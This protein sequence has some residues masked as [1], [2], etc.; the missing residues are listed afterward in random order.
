[1]P[2]TQ[3]LQ[4]AIN[5][6]AEAIKVRTRESSPLEWAKAQQGMGLIYWHMSLSENHLENLRLA[7]LCFTSALELFTPE[8][9][10]FERDLCKSSLD[11]V[12]EQIA[13]IINENNHR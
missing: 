11:H 8:S 1:M 7:E 5:A 2:G 12:K 3:V 10:P 6:Y 9:A 4:E 13:E